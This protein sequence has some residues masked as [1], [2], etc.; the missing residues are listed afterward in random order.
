M[1]DSEEIVKRF[2]DFFSQA[3]FADAKSIMHPDI[4]V[5]WPNTKEVF[6]GRDRFVSINDEYPGRWNISIDKLISSDDTVIS[7]VRVE[8]IEQTHSFY[9][10]S[11]FTIQD[12]NITLDY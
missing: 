11:F 3:K 10:T 8:S 12:G 6:R 5:W 2:W 7:V 9:A 1:N 4:V